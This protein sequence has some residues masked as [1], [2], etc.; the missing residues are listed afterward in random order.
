MSCFEGFKICRLL[1][2]TFSVVTSR[3]IFGPC[4]SIIA[5]RKS[6]FVRAIFTFSRL[7][8]CDEILFLLQKI[9]YDKGTNVLFR[10]KYATVIFY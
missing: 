8:L 10:N 3:E 1:I 4:G 7:V 9:S 2:M 6:G 5:T